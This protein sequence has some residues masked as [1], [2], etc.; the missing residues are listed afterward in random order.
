MQVKV[1]QDFGWP[2]YTK[3]NWQPIK[4]LV[5]VVIPHIHIRYHSIIVC[6]VNSSC[7]AVYT[8]LVFCS[9]EGYLWGTELPP[10]HKPELLR[11]QTCSF[12]LM[13]DYVKKQW[14]WFANAYSSE[15]WGISISTNYMLSA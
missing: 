9:N 8:W 6:F 15:G 5:S 13:K 10:S 1:K 11:G 2:V 4:S 7:I 14:Q 3:C 12:A